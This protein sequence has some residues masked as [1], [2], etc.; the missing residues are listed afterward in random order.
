MVGENCRKG[1]YTVAITLPTRGWGSAWGMK[2]VTTSSAA[3][4]E[5]APVRRARVSVKML[6]R[7]VYIFC[8]ESV[9]MVVV[10][11]LRIGNR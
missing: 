1:S 3:R 5:D 4:T 10:W 7:M 9:V 2:S 8:I 6:R 11:V